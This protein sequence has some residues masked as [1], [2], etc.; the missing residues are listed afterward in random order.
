MLDHRI[1]LSDQDTVLANLSNRGVEQS[2]VHQLSELVDAR[3]SAS[4][5]EE[6]LRQQLNVAAGSVQEKARAGEHE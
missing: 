5:A 4:Q 3:R 1:F 6:S 2:I